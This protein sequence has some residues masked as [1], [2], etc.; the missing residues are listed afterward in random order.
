[1]TCTHRAIRSLI[2]AFL[3]FSLSAC[4][5]SA[6]DDDN[7]NSGDNGGWT[8]APGTEWPLGNVYVC[9][10]ACPYGECDNNQN[11]TATPCTDIYDGA[12]SKNSDFCGSLTSNEYCIDIGVNKSSAIPAAVKCHDGEFVIDMCDDTHHCGTSDFLGRVTASCH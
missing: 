4:D 7:S 11:Y 3:L 1:M 9:M 6:D 12:V 2:L 5:S 8:A 10:G